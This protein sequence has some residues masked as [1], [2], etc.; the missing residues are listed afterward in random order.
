M[1]KTNNDRIVF[2][3][4]ILSILAFSLLLIP[5]KVFATPGYVDNPTPYV[6]SLNPNSVNSNMVGRSI[7]VA[8][9]GNGFIPSSIAR[10]NGADRL[11]TFIDYSHLLV[12]INPND[13]FNTNGFYINVFNGFPG[14]GYSNAEFFTIKSETQITSTNTN[15]NQSSTITKTDNTAV[16]YNSS[17]NNTYPNTTQTENT[18]NSNAN[19]NTSNLAATAIFGSAS[20]LP[21][22]LIQWIIFAIIILL[23]VILV[24]R[25]FGAKKNYEETPM[26]TL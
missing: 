22:G 7:V 13:T 9:T 10:V 19:A 25:I 24:R 20:F 15:Y 12:R 8:I 2:S 16:N 14:G 23:I 6:A 11:T 17:A 18:E 21:S 26:K 1:N 3:L 5:V 4:K